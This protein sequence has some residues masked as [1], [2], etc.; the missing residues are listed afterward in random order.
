MV[1]TLPLDTAPCQLCGHAESDLPYSV[2]IL[3][4]LVASIDSIDSKCSN[5]SMEV[6]LPTLLRN[7]VMLTN[8]LVN[9]RT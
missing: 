2:R 4:I 1:S 8:K 6:S 5:K 7:Y 9:R 3:F